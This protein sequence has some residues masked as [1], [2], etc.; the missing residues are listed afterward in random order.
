VPNP[1]LQSRTTTII[2]TTTHPPASNNDNDVAPST[3]AT[4]N[5]D[6]G[7]PDFAM[8]TVS[9]MDGVLVDRGLTAS[10]SPLSDAGDGTPEV[11]EAQGEDVDADADGIYAYRY[12][13]G[14]DDGYPYP[15]QPLEGGERRAEVFDPD[16][17]FIAEPESPDKTGD[18]MLFPER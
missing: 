16:G 1:S 5:E 14:E 3:D 17:E 13:Y 15:Y 6:M 10:P 18:L 4:P 12:R 2:P 7:S 9:S 8:Q 11:R